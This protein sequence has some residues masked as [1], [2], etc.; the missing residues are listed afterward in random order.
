MKKKMLAIVLSIAMII[1][2]VPAAAF[3]ADGNSSEQPTLKGPRT[4]KVG[5]EEVKVYDCVYFGE[6]PQSSDGNDGFKTE[7]IKWRVL[8]VV[9][10]D[11]DDEEFAEDAFLLAD[12]NLDF[13]QYNS[14]GDDDNFDDIECQDITWENS[15]LRGWLNGYDGKTPKNYDTRA[16]EQ[17]NSLGID[18]SK[19]WGDSFINTALEK[20]Q[21]E[22]III[23]YDG[24]DYGYSSDN[25]KYKARTGERTLDRITLLSIEEAT[26]SKYGF[27]A[28]EEDCTA[29]VSK[30]TAYAASRQK[31]AKAGEPYLYWLR[32][33]G[34]CNESYDY[35]QEAAIVYDDGR[36]DYD[37][38]YV[39]CYKLAVRPALH[40]DIRDNND[41]WQYAGTVRADGTPVREMKNA[42][43]TLESTEAAYAKDIPFEP[44]VTVE[45]DGERLNEGVDYT[46]TYSDN[47]K[48]GKGS[49]KVTGIN[50][51]IGTVKKTIT[52]TPLDLK[53]DNGKLTVARGSFTYTGKAIKPDVTVIVMGEELVQGTDYTVKYENN[54]NASTDSTEE[55]RPKVTVTG[56]G[57]YK[58]SLTQKFTI[59][60]IITETTIPGEKAFEYTGREITPAPTVKFLD[61][62][63]TRGVD[64]TVKYENNINVGTAG[65][66]VD[67]TG[68]KGEYLGQHGDAEFT[69]LPADMA[70]TEI[71]LDP[72]KALYTGKSVRPTPTVTYKDNI[73]KEGEDYTVAYESN[74]EKGTGKITVIGHGN[75]KGEKSA[76]FEILDNSLT[77]AEITVPE[78]VE[79]NGKPQTPKV[80]VK[81]HGITLIRDRD[82]VLT[83]SSN[84]EAGAAAVEIRGVGDYTG[85]VTANFEI[86]AAPSDEG[87][88]PSGDSTPAKVTVKAIQITK[89]T[90][91]TKGF[92]VKW[93]KSTAANSTG[94]Q[95]RYSTKS[96][97]AGAKSIKVK[98][99]KNTVKKITKLK[100]KK[101]YYVQVRVYKVKNGKTYYSK[102]SAKKYVTTK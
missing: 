11:W 71:T 21:Q 60:P 75:Y 52:I 62:V 20:E 35:S 87:S 101:K 39:H 4:Y 42:T 81:M 74:L 36:L 43:V 22:R 98:G 93:A 10:S 91:L 7:A 85:I 97:I 51:Y 26:N 16:P 5:D 82:Y 41:I 94:Y 64:Y 38:R 73:L 92:T 25:P 6:Y 44:K 76:D 32:S 37:G 15:T 12:M 99:Y 63:L 66:T 84:V 29:R 67:G 65:L 2:T 24:R 19:N 28:G 72:L 100:A 77:A 27:P 89:L 3:A 53:E 48:A 96:S 102:W 90:R 33:P 59:L 83:Y 57:N 34:Y 80:S 45:Y 18:Y 47:D 56:K 86:T 31:W 30:N 1:T 69:I 88:N 68:T 50:G 17:R 23:P 46:L 70:K 49:V 78:A 55:N 61:K 8:S 79:Y 58:G 40:L 95:V 54:I 14:Y 13:K 9:D